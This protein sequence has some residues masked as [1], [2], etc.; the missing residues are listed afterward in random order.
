MTVFHKTSL[1]DPETQISFN[2]HLS[3]DTVF[4]FKLFARVKAILAFKLNRWQ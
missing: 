4:F 3:Q 1:I 2:F